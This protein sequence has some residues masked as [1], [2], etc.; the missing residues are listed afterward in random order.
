[1]KKIRVAQVGF[2]GFGHG[3]ASCYPIDDC[4]LVAL[5]DI[6]EEVLHESDSTINIGTSSVKGLDAIAKY[7]DF[8]EMLKV[9]KP[10]MVDCCLPTP[11]HVDYAIMAM[12]AGCHVLSEKPMAIDS[13][14]AKRLMTA[15][16]RYGV[17]VMVAQVLRF[18]PVYEIIREA[19]QDGRYGKL[20]RYDARRLSACPK[21]AWYNDHTQSGGAILDL[22][23]H[24]TDFINSLLGMPDAVTSHGI[25]G[26]TG[27]YDDIMT[28]YE[29]ADG[30]V[31][32]ATGSW[33]RDGWDCRT[34]AIFEK[35]TI[36]T[37]GDDKYYISRNGHEVHTVTVENPNGYRNEI[38]Y[39]AQCI[40]KDEEPVRC[41]LASTYDSIRI[42]EAEARSIR[43]GRTVTLKK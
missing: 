3:H 11:L 5:C 1:M 41:P 26:P 24:D 23:L 7:T 17:K 10:D 16:K 38:R 25:V 19:Y 13:S 15:A 14:E 21:N 40:L 8:Q 43:T 29:Y 18:C 9:E 42:V 22:H 39:L 2:G 12:K 33:C 4:K 31:V 6:D 34:A 27:G 37:Y 20:L 35:A 36:T 32:T 28:T 30:P